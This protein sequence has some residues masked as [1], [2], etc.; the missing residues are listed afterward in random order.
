MDGGSE[1]ERR[2]EE[3]NEG[4]KVRDAIKMKREKKEKG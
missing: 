1:G 2:G 4:K 3:W